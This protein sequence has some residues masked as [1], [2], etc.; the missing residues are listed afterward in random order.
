MMDLGFADYV[1]SS[2]H[3]T[4]KPAIT[5]TINSQK[6]TIGNG[7]TFCAFQRYSDFASRGCTATKISNPPKL[8][9]GWVMCA[10]TY[11]S[12]GCDTFVNTTIL[13]NHM[14]LLFTDSLCKD[15]VAPS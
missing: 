15:T 8:T 9:Q 3:L 4:P 13:H 5:A 11:H 14:S 7:T 2:G 10:A 1:I 6:T 12:R